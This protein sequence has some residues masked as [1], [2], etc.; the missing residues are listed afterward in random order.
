MNPV[1]VLDGFPDGLYQVKTSYLCAGL[2]IEGRKVV[3][4][5]PILRKRLPYWLTKAKLVST[6]GRTVAKADRLL[7]SKQAMRVRLPSGAP[8]DSFNW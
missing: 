8:G 1:V 7:P 3:A 2:V 5:A 4:C 6:C